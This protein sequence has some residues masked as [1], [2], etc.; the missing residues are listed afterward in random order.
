MVIVVDLQLSKVKG[1]YTLDL[2]R[3]YGLK[4]KFQRLLAKL[5]KKISSRKSN[6]SQTDF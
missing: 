5:I 3:E 4:N 1:H 2:E 6:P